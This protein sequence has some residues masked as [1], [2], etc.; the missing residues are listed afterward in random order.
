MME[1]GEEVGLVMSPN[2]L[3]D[4][5]AKR[6]FNGL[7]GGGGVGYWQVWNTI[8]G[9]ELLSLEGETNNTTLSSIRIK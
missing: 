7:T 4:H 3:L 6:R 5:I 9:D 2:L 1:G 8:T